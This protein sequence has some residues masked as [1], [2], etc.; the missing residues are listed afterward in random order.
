MLLREL[1]DQRS[2]SSI[3]LACTSRGCS[4]CAATW[5]TIWIVR[6]GSDIYVVYTHNWLDDPALSRF[7]TLDRRI[8]SKVRTCDTQGDQENTQ[9]GFASFSL[10]ANGV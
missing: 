8:A 5:F 3:T 4:C 6:P 7:T 9:F 10:V 1:Q 2:V